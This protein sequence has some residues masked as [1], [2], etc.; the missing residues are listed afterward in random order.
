MGVYDTNTADPAV[1]PVSKGIKE[2][3][4]NIDSILNKMN[5]DHPGDIIADILH[6]CDKNS[7]DFENLLYLGKNYYLEEKD[8]VL[9]NYG[10]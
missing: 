6:W 9:I 3:V 7:E 5:A 2:S 1:Q 10:A 4:D 8:E